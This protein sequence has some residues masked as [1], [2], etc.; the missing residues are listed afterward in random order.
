MIKPFLFL[1]VLLLLSGCNLEQADTPARATVELEPSATITPT[2]PGVVPNP[3]GVGTPFTTATA[4][5]T[6]T[7]RAAPQLDLPLPTSTDATSPTAASGIALPPLDDFIKQDNINLSATQI[8]AITY[9]VALD[10]PGNERVFFVL[11][12]PAGDIAWEHVSTESETDTAE[13][14]I[15][16]NGIHE[17][18]VAL[19]NASGRFG[20]IDGNYS[21]QYELR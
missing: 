3:V 14:D 10:N 20:I 19:Q 21:V 5:P 7:Q 15:T 13:I 1:L 16:S 11:L 8:L 17:L 12:D 4:S 6:A 2:P 18:L 9:T